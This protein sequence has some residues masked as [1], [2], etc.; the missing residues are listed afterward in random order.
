MKMEKIKRLEKRLD[1][2]WRICLILVIA[3]FLLMLIGNI[4]RSCVQTTKTEQIS[5]YL[6]DRPNEVHNAENYTLWQLQTKK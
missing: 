6:K 5:A 4:V 3:G 1:N 2:I